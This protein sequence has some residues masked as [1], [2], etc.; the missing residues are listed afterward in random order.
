MKR[1]EVN[2]KTRNGAVSRYALIAMEYGGEM[3]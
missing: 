3:Q 2:R 1:K